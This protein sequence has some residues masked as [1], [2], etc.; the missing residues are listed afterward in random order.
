MRSD[1]VVVPS[2]AFDQNLSLVQ[3]R[4]DLA[5]EQFVPEPGVEALA[6]TGLPWTA[7]LDEQCLYTDPAEPVPD[8][9]GGELGPIVRPDVLRWPMLYE[10]LGMSLI[11]R[12]R[13]S[14]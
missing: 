5:V 6:V 3:G 2:P 11:E 12:L 7:R 1:G 10:Q 14:Q 13:S 4:E 8:C 9:L